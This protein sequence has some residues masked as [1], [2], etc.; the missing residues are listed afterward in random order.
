VFAQLAITTMLFWIAGATREKDLFDAAATMP[1]FLLVVAAG[2]H[3]GLAIRRAVAEAGDDPWERR[4]TFTAALRTILVTYALLTSLGVAASAWLST[5]L[6][7]AVDQTARLGALL[8]I[9]LFGYFLLGMTLVLAQGT[10]REG[11]RIGG[12]IGPLLQA[13]GAAVA[14]VL[15]GTDVRIEDVAWGATAGAA[16]ALALVAWRVERFGLG[17]DWTTPWQHRSLKTFAGHVLP[18]T[19]M[20][21]VLAVETTLPALG[22]QFAGE[23]TIGAVAGVR[24]VVVSVAWIALGSSTT[25]EGRSSIRASRLHRSGLGLGV[26][27]GLATPLVVTLFDWGRMQPAATDTMSLLLVIAAVGTPFVVITI[28]SLPS[29]AARSTV[30]L[31]AALVLAT[32][33]IAVSAGKAVGSSAVA[34]TWSLHVAAVAS[35]LLYRS[36]S[37][38]RVRPESRI[39]MSAAAGAVAALAVALGIAWIGDRLQSPAPITAVLGFTA[40]VAAWAQT[41]KAYGEDPSAIL[42]VRRSERGGTG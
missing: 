21:T 22:G 41:L 17:F 34:A 20:A 15:F 13:G 23:G 8:R 26:L 2:P 28:G 38:D 18:G 14:T 36:P 42:G 27:V 32:L 4:R 33:P 37:V 24:W 12:W 35:V 1:W 11:N 39:I 29:A 9:T 31:T 16:T 6:F 7:P 3:A 40:A 30:V 19:S 5:V 25:S 10:A